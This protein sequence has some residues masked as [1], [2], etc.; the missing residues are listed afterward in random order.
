MP[1][2]LARPASVARRCRSASRPSCGAV[3]K[4]IVNDPRTQAWM[5]ARSGLPRQFDFHSIAREVDGEIVSAF[6]FDSFQEKSCALH[7]ATERPYTRA[8]L[9]E[10]FWTMFCQWGY[11]R[12]YAIIQTSNAKS[13]N[14]GRRLGFKAVGETPDLWFGVLI[15]KDCKWVAPLEKQRSC[16]ADRLPHQPL[17]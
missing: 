1:T 9:Q 11:E 6:G 16:Q 17:H 12:C 4:L 5:H 10:V 8:L 15:K 14:L 3:D 13:L 2:L 7:T